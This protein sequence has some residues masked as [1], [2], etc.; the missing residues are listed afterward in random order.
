MPCKQFRF[1]PATP[2]PMMPVTKFFQRSVSLKSIASKGFSLV[3]MLV[4]MAVI[5]LLSLSVPAIQSALTAGTFNSNVAQMNDLLRAGY[6][7]AIARNTYVWVGLTQMPGNR[8][9]GM[10]VTYS[11]SG[12]P[13]DVLSATPSY[14]FKPVILKNLSLAT[15]STSAITNPDRVTSTSAVAQ[16][17]STSN[18]LTVNSSA[19]TATSPTI[20]ASLGGILQTIGTYGSQS[21]P[22]ALM[23]ITPSGQVSISTGKIPWLEIGLQPSLASSKE[24]AVLQINSLNGRVVQFLP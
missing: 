13:T 24:A 16:V 15:I 11:P 10:V 17:F 6:A 12:N 9:V 19:G 14:L 18:N 8:G 2:P 21:A 23:E 20:P 5:A 3:E 7:A 4:V 1:T 22:G